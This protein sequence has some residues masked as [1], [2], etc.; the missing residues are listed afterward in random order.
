MPST[1]IEPPVLWK[2]RFFNS[3]QSADLFEKLVGEYRRCAL[4]APENTVQQ[5]GCAM[6]RQPEILT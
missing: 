6:K 1:L 2:P 3:E 4:E 5:R